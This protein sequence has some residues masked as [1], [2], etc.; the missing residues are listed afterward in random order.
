MKKVFSVLLFLLCIL[1]IFSRNET[2]SAGL[3]LEWNMDSRHNFAGGTLLAFDYRLP[4]FTSVG[5]FLTG[6]T[7]FNNTY[8]IEPVLVFRAYYREYEFSGPF[9][10]NEL[11][12]SF[13]TEDGRQTRLPL[14]GFGTGYRFHAGSSFYLEPYIRIGYPFAFGIGVI[15]GILF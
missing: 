1:P 6:S 9:F 4:H 8:V 2:M 7:N 12:I 11:G 15:A 14:V 3:G 5:L 13:I 10:Q